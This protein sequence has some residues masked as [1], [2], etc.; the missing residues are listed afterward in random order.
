MSLLY[1]LLPR[2][3]LDCAAADNEMASR[4][5]STSKF[6][7]MSMGFATNNANL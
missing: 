3:S 6:F 7:F 1:V 2:Y 5:T 4:V